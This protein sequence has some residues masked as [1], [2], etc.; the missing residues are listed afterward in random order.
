MKHISCHKTIDRKKPPETHKSQ[1]C[2]WVTKLEGKSQ[3]QVRNIQMLISWSRTQLCTTFFLILDLA[4]LLFHFASILSPHVNKYLIG[5][6]WELSIN[7]NRM[8][9]TWN[10]MF[11]NLTKNK[12]PGFKITNSRRSS[13]CAVIVVS[14]DGW[15]REV[16]FIAFDRTNSSWS[17][18][19]KAKVFVLGVLSRMEIAPWG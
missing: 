11:W 10:L 14:R 6:G 2:A 13:N 18:H 1:S 19:L 17:I 12:S 16:L 3:E 8:N 5:E 4:S 15:N 9:Q 7:T